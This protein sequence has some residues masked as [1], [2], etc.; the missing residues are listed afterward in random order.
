[1]RNAVDDF[2]TYV[3][4]QVGRLEGGAKD[5][6]QRKH[7]NLLAYDF[8]A[9]ARLK[10]WGSFDQII[11]VRSRVLCFRSC[12][13]TPFLQE[14]EIHRDSKLYGMLADIT[15]CSEAPNGGRWSSPQ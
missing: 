15:L 9:A 2:R 7:A 4:G 11:K 5:D 8:E 12:N 1:M 6:L 14:S 13:S 3:D 10:A